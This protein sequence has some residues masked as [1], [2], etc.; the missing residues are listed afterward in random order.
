[1]RYFTQGIH[2]SLSFSFS[3]YFSFDHSIIITIII[4]TAHGARSTADG[5]R[6][7]DGVECK[8]FTSH[9]NTYVR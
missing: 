5:S 8:C 3:F 9:T 7:M 4:I 2:L 6:V 1:M